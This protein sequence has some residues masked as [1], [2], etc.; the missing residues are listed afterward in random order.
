MLESMPFLP[1]SSRL[2]VYMVLLFYFVCLVLVL[3]YYQLIYLIVLRETDAFLTG[4]SDCFIIIN[5]TDCLV[6]ECLRAMDIYLLLW[7][8]TY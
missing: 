7:C 3:Y 8:D 2:C 5:G 1:T 6:A 4:T